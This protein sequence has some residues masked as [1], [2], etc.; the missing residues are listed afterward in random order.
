M[1]NPER[2]KDRRVRIDGATATLTHFAPPN[3]KD[4]AKRFPNVDPN[5]M[6]FTYYPNI[7][8][9]YEFPEHTLRHEIVHIK[10]QKRI[11]PKLWWFLYLRFGWFRKW[12]EKEAY[13][14]EYRCMTPQ[15][16]MSSL[17]I[18]SYAFATC[19]ELE[20]TIQEAQDLIT[21]K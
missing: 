2:L 13:Q 5:K 10:Q 20:M 15:E 14:R 12:Q 1:Y 11:G 8:S 9:V 3:Y 4:I 16:R 19:Y 6:V 21:K 17:Q 7:H 18:L